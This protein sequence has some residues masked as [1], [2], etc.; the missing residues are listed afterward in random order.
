MFNKRFR[1]R[2]NLLVLVSAILLVLYSIYG[3][4]LKFSAYIADLSEVK[5]PLSPILNFFANSNLGLLIIFILVGGIFLVRSFNICK[6]LSTKKS[7]VRA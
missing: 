1:L 6:K 5:I 3:I 7:K 4:V 2:F